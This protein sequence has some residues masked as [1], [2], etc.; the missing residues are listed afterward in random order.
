MRCPLSDEHAS[1]NSSIPDLGDPENGLAPRASCGAPADQRVSRR[2]KGPSVRTV[3]SPSRR[4][5]LHYE[6][7]ITGDAWRHSQARSAELLA[8]GG[9]C[10]LCNDGRAS[11]TL[12]VHHRTYERLGCEIADDL[13]TLC[14]PCHDT[15]TNMLRAREM[16]ARTPPRPADLPRLPVCRTRVD[17]LEDHR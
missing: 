11:T 14:E 17:N 3:A 7:Y 9:R 4:P 5:S 10:R 15:V 16:A 6:S 1:L 2:R 13:T 12:T 8:S